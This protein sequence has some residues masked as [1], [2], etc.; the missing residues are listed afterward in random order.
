MKAF[1][2]PLDSVFINISKNISD[3]INFP[4]FSLIYSLKFWVA[5]FTI[6]AV[7]TLETILSAIAI[8]KID[9]QKRHTNLAKD[10]RAIGIGNTICGSIGALRY[11]PAEDDP[12]LAGDDLSSASGAGSR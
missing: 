1:S 10:I 12:R 2:D 9:P 7:G 8:D 11:T 5:T 6:Y 4:N 3:T